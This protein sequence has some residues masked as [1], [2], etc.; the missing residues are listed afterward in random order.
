MRASKISFRIS[1]EIFFQSIWDEVGE[2]E[3][4]RDRLLFEIEQECL[5]VYR[6]KVD[7][8]N[9]SRA[10]LHQWIA[11]IH[12]QIVAL[13]ASLGDRPPLSQVNLPRLILFF[14]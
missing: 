9:R 5:D 11:E 13:A 8:A 7:L 12:A 3:E 14:S 6:R 2:N 10:S 1:D 4:E